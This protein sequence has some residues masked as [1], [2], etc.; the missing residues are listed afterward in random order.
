VPTPPDLKIPAFW[1]KYAPLPGKAGQL[2]F[3]NGFARDFPPELSKKLEFCKINLTKSGI[4]AM[5]V[6]TPPHFSGSP[7]R[8]LNKEHS[9]MARG[10]KDLGTPP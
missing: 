5:M 2:Y 7:P 4:P 3:Q 8:F 10:D 1:R 6:S 9:K